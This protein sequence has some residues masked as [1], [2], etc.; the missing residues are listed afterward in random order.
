[1]AGAAALAL[2]AGAV[3]PG[4]RAPRARTAPR[5]ARPPCPSPSRAASA[6]IPPADVGAVIRRTRYGVP[7]ITARDYESAAYGQAYA[8]AED[9]L[10]TLAETVVTIAGE[11]S[12]YF[13]PDKSWVF[14]GN[15]ATY[16]NL[17]SDFFYGRINKDR[18]VEKL[19]AKRPPQGPLPE[20][21]QA[22]RGF[23]R[24]YN[25]YLRDVGRGQGRAR[26][27]LQRQA[28]GAPAEGDRHLPALLP[29]RQPGL[30]GRGDRRH[31]EGALRGGRQL[32]HHLPAQVAGARARA[33]GC[34]TSA[35]WA[36][37]PTASAATPPTTGA[38]W[39]SATRTSPGPA[40]SGCTRTTS[41]SPARST[42]R[43]PRSTACRPC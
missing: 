1:M 18:T 20:I 10:C 23:V 8:F 28:V 4:R 3:R 33:A 30:L 16:N 11:R 37:T 6:A 12:R 17:D 25:A 43:A 26:P 22:T 31:L 2:C 34:A 40:P 9:N 14:S 7:H 42:S 15:S 21:K 32:A 41:Q 38:A 13:G 19:I 35:A 5:P 24:G 39:C 27:A 29:A 36:P